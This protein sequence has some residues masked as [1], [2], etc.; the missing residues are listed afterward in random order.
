MNKLVLSGIL[1]IIWAIVFILFQRDKINSDSQDLLSLGNCKFYIEEVTDD[2]SRQHG[3]SGRSSL[4]DNCGMLFVFPKIDKYGFWMK[5]MH[6]PLDIIWIRD[7]KIVEIKEDA[8]QNSKETFYPSEG[9]DKVLEINANETRN[10]NIKI[11]DEL[12]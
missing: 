12:K 2:E 7:N 10:C 11:G 8:S 1:L 5:D 4:C 3:L 6:F 9:I